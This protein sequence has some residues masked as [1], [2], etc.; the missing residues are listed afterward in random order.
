MQ[1]MTVRRL[2][3]RKCKIQKHMKMRS[4]LIILLFI[5]S[6]C[7]A[8]DKS[9]LK[10]HKLVP[11]TTENI[12]GTIYY[13]FSSYKV[14]TVLYGEISKE[15]IKK[16]DIEKSYEQGSFRVNIN[17]KEKYWSYFQLI[18][19]NFIGSPIGIIFNDE[20]IGS[21]V[22]NMSMSKGMFGFNIST[23]DKAELV[24]K[25]LGGKN[26]RIFVEKK[27]PDYYNE[28]YYPNGNHLF[29][30]NVSIDSIFLLYANAI[31]STPDDN[32]I[33]RRTDIFNEILDWFYKNSEKEYLIKTKSA[34]GTER[35]DNYVSK[36]V[37]LKDSILIDNETIYRYDN[38]VI[39]YYIV[40]LTKAFT[41]NRN[42]SDIEVKIKATEYLTKYLF[43]KANYTERGILSHQGIKQNMFLKNLNKKKNIKCLVENTDDF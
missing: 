34:D 27:L 39:P 33:D 17:L 23:K 21:P 35:I 5:S 29:E 22:V 18:T 8:Q 9:V 28:D 30:Q 11:D 43:K 32:T 3:V 38:S 14:D 13:D 40:C 36:F 31:L 16:I 4:Y 12:T 41:E 1:P 2:T 15:M 19:E 10:I 37:F 24:Y 25:G 20:L 42:L 26:K 6:I 7:N